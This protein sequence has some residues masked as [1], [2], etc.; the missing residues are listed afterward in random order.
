MA[1][2]RPNTRLRWRQPN[3][4]PTMSS[5]VWSIDEITIFQKPINNN[6]QF[7]YTTGCNTSTPSG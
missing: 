6:L 7:S 3:H 5:D 4:S 2:R 1:A